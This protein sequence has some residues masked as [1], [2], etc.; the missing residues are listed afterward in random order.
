MPDPNKLDKDPPLNPY[1]AGNEI[2]NG[3]TNESP[4]Q[5]PFNPL[6]QTLGWFCLIVIS[7]I[8][9][10]TAFFFTCFG[11]IGLVDNP[12][13]ISAGVGLLTMTAVLYFGGRSL[14]ANSNKPKK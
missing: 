4:R 1:A 13:A 2:D 10:C 6:F 7:P 3:P 9:G 5:K 14:I 12:M 11:T 8:L